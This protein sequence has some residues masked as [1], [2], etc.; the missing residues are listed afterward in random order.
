MLLESENSALVIFFPYGDTI[1]EQQLENLRHSCRIRPCEIGVPEL[2]ARYNGQSRCLK[3]PI[4]L[5][6]SLPAT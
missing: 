4:W 6:S 1:H 3:L 5:K 2:P